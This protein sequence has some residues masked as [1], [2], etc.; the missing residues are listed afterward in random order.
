MPLYPFEAPDGA[1]I[2]RFYRMAD[3]PKFGSV[4]VED[5]ISYVRRPVM[6]NVVIEDTCV[7]SSSL[8]R[9]DKRASKH[10]KAGKPAFET[11]RDITE[12]QARAE[13]EWTWD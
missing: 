11:K 1:V 7:V 8:P 9:W 3:A 10:T 4:L 6:V 5:G 12:Y 2:E 13:N